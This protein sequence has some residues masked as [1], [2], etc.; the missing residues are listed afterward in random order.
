MRVLIDA[1]G[2]N[3]EKAGVGVYALN[4]LDSLTAIPR[5]IEF[6]LLL[7]DDDPEIDFS[8]RPKV[9]VIRVPAYLFRRLPLRFLL[10][11]FYL[12]ILLWR[13][14]IDVLHSL[15]YAFPFFTFGTRRVVTFHDMTFFAMPE[16]HERLKVIYFTTFMRA[17]RRL[18]DH[19]IFISQSARND[20]TLRLGFLRGTASV[21]P[22]GKGKNFRADLEYDKASLLAKYELAEEFILFIGT[23]EPRK[24]LL[25]LV[26]AFAE[27]APC[28][29]A[30]QLVI[31]GRKGWMINQLYEDVERRG[32]TGRVVFPGFVDERDKASLL[33]ACTVFV[34]PS[35]YEGFGLPALEALA[36]GAPTVTSNTSSLPEVVGDAAVLIDPTDTS[37]LKRAINDLIKTPS[38]R[39][40]LHEKGPIQA[41]QFSWERTADATILVYRLLE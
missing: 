21:I 9:T 4:L 30:L 37:A 40:R 16:M 24:N 31:A 26:E 2:V 25:R 8:G 27:L 36:C 1:T 41:A 7:Q 28:H 32:L 12:P 23:L 13:L 19:A 17:M 33:A 35:L 10:E 20:Y 5:G 3:R 29:P 6:F 18:A 11:Q 39:A 34:Y 14:R 38:L 15:H 22:H